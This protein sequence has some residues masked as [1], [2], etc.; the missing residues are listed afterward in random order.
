MVDMLLN[1]V[2]RFDWY[3]LVYMIDDELESRLRRL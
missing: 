1:D 2:E 3:D